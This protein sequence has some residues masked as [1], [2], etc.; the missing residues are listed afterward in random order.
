MVSGEYH[1]YGPYQ[2][3]FGFG[4]LTIDNGIAYGE[5]FETVT[6][7]LRFEGNGVRIDG[8]QMRKSGGTAEGAAFV[9][10]NGTYSFNATGPAHSAGRRQGDGVS[11]GAAHGPARVQ[12]RWHRHVRRAAL[13]VPRA[14]PRPVRRRRRRGRSDGPPRRARR[15]HDDGDRGRVAAARGV[16]HRAASTSPRRRTPTSRCALPT[17]RSIPTRARSRSASRR[18]RRRS[19]AAR[20]ASSVSSRTPT[21]WSST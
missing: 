17:R 15:Q 10:W 21:G 1:L 11:A 19:A 16:G 20:C 18:S 13:P 6:G 4:T 3:P 12:R 5:P 7:S 9:G 14:H 2:G 8:I